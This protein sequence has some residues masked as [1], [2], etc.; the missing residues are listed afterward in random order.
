M[1]E[2]CLWVVVAPRLSFLFLILSY[3]IYCIGVPFVAGVWIWSVF[4]LVVLVWLGVCGFVMVFL[5]GG[6]GG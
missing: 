3:V 5:G 2:D 6:W 1:H 4:G